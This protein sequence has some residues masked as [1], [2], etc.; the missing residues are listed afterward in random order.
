MHITGG[1]FRGRKLNILKE[2]GVRP[3]LSKVRESVF[4]MLQNDIQ[5]ALMLDMFAGSGIMGLEA[6]SRGAKKVYFMEKD[7]KTAK[8]LSENL[9]KF[10][11]E[12]EVIYGDSLKSLNKLENIQ[13]DIIFMDPPYAT[14]LVIEG[15]K[16]IIKAKKLKDTGIIVVEHPSNKK[17]DIPED[18]KIIKQKKYGTSRIRLLILNSQN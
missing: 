8:I 10:D 2:K 14:D 1:K 6:L 4:N 11:S 16:A 17:I 13:F 12:S 3:T 15:L 7:P 5:G 9:K 18:F